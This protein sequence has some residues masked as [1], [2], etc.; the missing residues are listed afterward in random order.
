[1]AD[2]ETV[3]VHC[4][5]RRGRARLVSGA[6]LIARG[7][8]GDRAAKHEAQMDHLGQAAV[9]AGTGTTPCGASAAHVLWS[10]G[11]IAGP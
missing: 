9:S 10:L 7:G 1:V 8:S 2:R 3:Y 6:W 5:A 11:E 4:R